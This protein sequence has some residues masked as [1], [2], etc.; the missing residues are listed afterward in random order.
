M[1][2]EMRLLWLLRTLIDW[3]RINGLTRCRSSADRSGVCFFDLPPEIRLNIYQLAFDDGTCQYYHTLL[4]VRGL[5]PCLCEGE[6][7]LQVSRL[8]RNEAISIF[9]G[10][11]LFRFVLK[12]ENRLNLLKW[13]ESRDEDA[14]AQIRHLHFGDYHD[15][16]QDETYWWPDHRYHHTLVSV[17][18]SERKPKA[19]VLNGDR[20]CCERPTME[21]TMPLVNKLLGAL[22]ERDGRA[23]LT[24]EDL[25]NLLH[26]PGWWT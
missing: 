2:G 19:R 13:I 10:Q 11:H 3:I 6:T 14:V 1:F 21:Y 23:V 20:I 9:Y 5:T 16:G 26:A 25:A 12:Q 24:K 7:L 17:D 4:P 8:V 15:L 22:P 18:L